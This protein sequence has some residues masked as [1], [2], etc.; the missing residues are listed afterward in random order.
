MQMGYH[1][2]VDLVGPDAV[3]CHVLQQQPRYGVGHPFAVLSQPRIDKDRFAIGSQQKRTDVQDDASVGLQLV[4]VR[5]PVR[6]G[7]RWEELARNKP[8]A[9]VR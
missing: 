1:H 5:L 4:A 6:F 9:P 2:H 3:V 7:H 8:K